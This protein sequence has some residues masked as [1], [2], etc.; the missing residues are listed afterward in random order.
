M[1]GVVAKL[2]HVQANPLSPVGHLYD[3]HAVVR[4]EIDASGQIRNYSTTGEPLNLVQ[5]LRLGPRPL[6]VQVPMADPAPG[7]LKRHGPDGLLETY[8]NTFRP[9]RGR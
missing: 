2:A 6:G 5:S 8:D 3:P 4:A 1:A 7:L 9:S